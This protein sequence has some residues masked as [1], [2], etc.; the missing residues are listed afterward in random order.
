VFQEAPLNAIITTFLFPPF[1]N[2]LF[3]LFLLRTFLATFLFYSFVGNL[4][5][6]LKSQFTWLLKRGDHSKSMIVHVVGN[7]GAVVGNM[8]AVVGTMG[9]KG[10][11]Q[12]GKWVK[13]CT[14]KIILG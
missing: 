4:L 2:F 3:F 12:Q 11:C 14:Q 6:F 9:A 13:L 7:M 10:F 1:P 5:F 8:G